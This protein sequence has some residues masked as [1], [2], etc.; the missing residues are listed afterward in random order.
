MGWL[1]TVAPVDGFAVR[2]TRIETLPLRSACATAS[3]PCVAGA[4]GEAATRG[5]DQG[6]GGGVRFVHGDG[7]PLPGC[8][9][10]GVG[11]LGT[12]GVL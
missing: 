2:G 12:C 4:V 10:R 11:R 6:A 8:T 3:A 9:A 5:A 7:A 1:T